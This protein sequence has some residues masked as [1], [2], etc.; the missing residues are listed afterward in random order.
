MTILSFGQVHGVHAGI[1]SS[2]VRTGEPLSKTRKTKK[3]MKTKYSIIMI[4]ASLALATPA[5]SQA[6]DIGRCG[7][8]RGTCGN[9]CDGQGFMNQGRGN[10]QAQGKGFRRGQRDGNGKG[11][12]QQ[13]RQRKRDGSGPGR[14]KQGV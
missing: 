10:G 2:V 12:G 5:I 14:N 1:V 9:E 4:V 3:D 7:Q 13:E 6:N 11:V 8:P